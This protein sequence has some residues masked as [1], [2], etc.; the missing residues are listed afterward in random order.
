MSLKVSAVDMQTKEDRD[1]FEAGVSYWQGFQ[2]RTITERIAKIKAL[3]LEPKK[4]TRPATQ[5]PGG[6]ARC[7]ETVIAKK[8][9]A[10]IINIYLLLLQFARRAPTAGR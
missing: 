7:S 8:L 6:G 3:G 10:V 2:D 4:A 9:L 5:D 1:K